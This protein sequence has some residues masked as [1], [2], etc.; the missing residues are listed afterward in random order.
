M[1]KV[2][3]KSVEV[4]VTHLHSGKPWL[5]GVRQ[6][7][8]PG[9]RPRDREG[10]RPRARLR[11][12]GRIDSGRLDLSGRAGPAVGALRRRP[13]RRK[14]ARAEREARPRELPQ[15]R[16]RVGDSVRGDRRHE[17]SCRTRR[18][19]W[20]LLDP[21]SLN[22]TS[23]QSARSLGNRVGVGA[24]LERDVELHTAVVARR[25]RCRPRRER[26][27]A[28]SG[29]IGPGRDPH[30]RSVSAAANQVV[31]RSTAARDRFEGADPR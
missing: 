18:T 14:R 23:S 26:R 19:R 7:V 9:R 30:E 31:R 20:L 4:K 27:I 21:I 22:P 2:A 11:P 12:R 3:P 17:V 13:A 24:V 16:R 10:L 28:G 1:R 5:T 6:S 29:S 25:R 15:R 8:R